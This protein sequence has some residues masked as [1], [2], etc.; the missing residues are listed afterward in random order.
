MIERMKRTGLPTAVAKKTLRMTRKVA[1]QMHAQLKSN[2]GI[3]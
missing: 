2:G 3:C 1:E